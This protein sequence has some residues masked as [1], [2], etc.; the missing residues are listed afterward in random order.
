MSDVW[1]REAAR[2]LLI[3][4][5]SRV[6]LTAVRDPGDG[7][8]AWI[9]PGGTVEPGETI[10]QTA[11]R[12][13]AE[14][15]D[16]PSVYALNGPVWTRS[17]FHTFAGRET[18]LHEWYFVASVA[19]SDIRDVRETGEGARYFEGWRWWTLGELVQHDGPLAP[20]ALATLLPP[21][22]RGELPAT[23]LHIADR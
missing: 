2:V 11:L 3:D 8:L 19:A 14:E 22:L 6:L 17:F 18:D 21:I 15:V 5:R 1:R 4:E 16:G 10:E 13:L 20:A 23:P 12:E 7:V 9:A